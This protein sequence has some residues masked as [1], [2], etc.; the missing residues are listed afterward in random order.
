MFWNTVPTLMIGRF[1]N[2]VEEINIDFAKRKNM[3]IIRRNSGGGTIYTDENTWQFSFITWK[4]NNQVKDFRE[5]TKPVI[6]ALGNLGIKTTFSGRN[7]ILLN[8][9]KISGNAQFSYKNRFLH[10]GSILFDANIENLVRALNPDDQKIISKGIKSIKER[11]VNLR[12]FLKNP[13]MTS[14]EFRDEMLKNLKKDMHV[15]EFEIDDLL[16]IEQINKNKFN[17]WDWNFGKSPEFSTS[18][19]KKFVGGRVDISLNIKNGLIANCK[20]TGDFFFNDDI[21]EFQQK[22]VGIKY[23][24]NDIYDI[25]KKSEFFFQNIS[26]DEILEL[27]C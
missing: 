11:V 15:L 2:T 14:S 13:Q 16:E 19:S 24:R 26:I 27:F 18:K 22:F 10:H 6:Q 1:Q 5:F 7:D 17:T 4:K 3:D 25:L 20:F 12:N 23:S 21:D 8:D 9:K